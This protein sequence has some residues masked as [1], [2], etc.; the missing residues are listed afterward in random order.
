MDLLDRVFGK[1]HFRAMIG[2]KAFAEI[3]MQGDIIHIRITSIPYFLK[4]MLYHALKRERIQS[5]KLKALKEA[6]YK[7][8]IK[9]GRVTHEI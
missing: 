3:I 4:A 2:E 1:L 7:I 8:V 5:H 9:W 6:G